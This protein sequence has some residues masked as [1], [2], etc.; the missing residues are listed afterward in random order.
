[1]EV[2][3]LAGAASC[4]EAAALLSRVWGRPLLEAGLPRAWSFTGNYVVGAFAEG[5]LIGAA[6]GFLTAGGALHSHITGVAAGARGLGV[7]R[8]IKRHQR[9][10]ALDRGIGRVEW[11]FDPLVRRNAHFNLEVLGALPDRYLT[12]FYG[13]MDDGLNAGSPSDRLH[14]VWELERE[15]PAAVPVTAELLADGAL[16]VLSCVDDRP[17]TT[18]GDAKVVLV[19]VPPDIEAL[20]G[21]RPA[22]AGEWRRSLRAALEPRTSAGRRITGITRDGFYVVEAP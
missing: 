16:T 10:W 8:A 1:M 2:A 18:P 13:A 6:A 12:D 4:R 20:R 19:A 14:T 5:A 3:E 11:T 9:A 22:V 21:A 7:G 15:R 17:L